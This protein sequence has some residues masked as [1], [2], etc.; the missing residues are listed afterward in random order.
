M[1][2]TR[3]TDCAIPV[4][5][6]TSQASERR[7]RGKSRKTLDKINELRAK[8]ILMPP[9]CEVGIAIIVLWVATPRSLVSGYRHFGWTFCLHKSWRWRKYYPSKHQHPPTRPRSATVQKTTILEILTITPVKTQDLI[10]SG[11]VNQT[12]ALFA[13]KLIIILLYYNIIRAHLMLVYF[14]RL[15]NYKLG[16]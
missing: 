3:Y 15:F 1:L 14:K 11:N 5:W 7:N 9:E 12:S 4:F 8:S 16:N 13:N 6:S 2:A 10:W